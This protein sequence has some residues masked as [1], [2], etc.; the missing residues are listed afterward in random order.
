MVLS[1]VKSVE[2]GLRS[3]RKIILSTELT[4]HSEKVEFLLA[5]KDVTSPTVVTLRSVFGVGSSSGPSKSDYT[6]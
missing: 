5:R 6:I 2:I 1:G 3:I 4:F